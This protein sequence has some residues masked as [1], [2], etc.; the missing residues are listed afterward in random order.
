[1][2]YDTTILYGESMRQTLPIGFMHLFTIA[3]IGNFD[4][5]KVS[6]EAK[7]GNILEVDLEYPN[8]VHDWH[9]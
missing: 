7:E 4:L 5:Q 1:M 9:N 3:E 2:Y 8:H 6:A